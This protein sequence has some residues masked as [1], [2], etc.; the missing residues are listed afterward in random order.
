MPSASDAV[1]IPNAR[2]HVAILLATKNGAR[3]LAEQL[4]SYADQTADRWSLH[5]SD[6]GSTDGT[7][8][9]IQQFARSHPQVTSIG[10]GPRQ[11]YIRNFLSLAKDKSIIADY[12]AFSDQD[13]IWYPDKIERALSFLEAVPKSIPALYFSR[14]E[15]VDE[16][17][18]HLGISPL[19]ARLAAFQ[20][21]LIQNMG[22]GNTMVFNAATKQLLESGRQDD[23]ASHD[24][25][26]YQVVTAVGGTAIY[27]KRPS[28]K[29][30]QHANNVQ[31]SMHGMR[32][33]R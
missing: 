33:F 28:L 5:V 23:V 4:R 29:Y 19:F 2:P 25:W 24:W 31:G 32:D 15:I 9:I 22:G 21:A 7:V 11:G 26:T 14:T 18:N 10:Q 17:L 12:F 1:Q 8:E 6:D 30:R 3:Y 16:N 13:D 27:D 20:N